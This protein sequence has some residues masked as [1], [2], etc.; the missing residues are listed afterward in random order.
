MFLILYVRDD[1]KRGTDVFVLKFYHEKG[2]YGANKRSVTLPKINVDSYGFCVT[3]QQER[4][5][6]KSNEL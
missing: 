1:A 6:V 3:L 2:G 5:F 4:T